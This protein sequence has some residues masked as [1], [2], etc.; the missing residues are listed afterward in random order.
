MRYTAWTMAFLFFLGATLSL[1][2]TVYISDYS[3]INMRSGMGTDYRIV[4]I[5]T[6]GQKVELVEQKEG[7]ARIRLDD[8]KEGWVLSR[9]VTDQEPCRRVLES[10]QQEL[11]RVQEELMSFSDK[12]AQLKE[13]NALLQTEADQSGQ[14]ASKL[15]KELD[16]LQAESADFFTLKEKLEA[17]QRENERQEQ[18]AQSAEAELKELRKDANWRWFLSGAAVL[19]FG[20]ILGSIS[21]R[22]RSSNLLR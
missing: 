7:W 10:V 4:S 2:D 5:L 8:G 17:A 16:S 13:Q 9:L 20:I 1:A 19:L 21:K 11:G 15:R 18:I 22:R 12:N 14:T 3:K 6:T